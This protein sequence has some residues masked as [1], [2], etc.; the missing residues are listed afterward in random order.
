MQNTPSERHR[1]YHIRMTVRSC[2]E[3]RREGLSSV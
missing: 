3:K 1:S 2:P